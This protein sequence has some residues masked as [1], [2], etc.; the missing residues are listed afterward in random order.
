MTQHAICWVNN[1]TIHRCKVLL[2]TNWTL[3]T[4]ICFLFK[5]YVK[6]NVACYTQ[7]CLIDSFRNIQGYAVISMSTL[8]L[9]PPTFILQ[10]IIWSRCLPIIMEAIYIQRKTAHIKRSE[11]GRKCS[12][13]TKNNIRSGLKMLQKSRI[14]HFKCYSDSV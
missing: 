9:W 6:Q 2:N 14:W 12:F 13:K 3:F 8:A 5:L 10:T 11:V 1:Q 7:V 4:P